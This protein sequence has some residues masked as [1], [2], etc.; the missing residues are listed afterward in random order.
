MAARERTSGKWPVPSGIGRGKRC[1]DVGCGAGTLSVQLAL[2]GA[3]QVTAIDI[4]KAAVANT[5][6][7]AFRNGVADHVD[8]EIVDLYAFHPQKQYDVIAASLYQMPT[9]PVGKLSS[10]RPVDFWG[11]NLLD[12]LIEMLPQL[13]KPDGIAYLLQ[14][15]LLSQSQTAQLFHDVGLE[16]RVVDFNLYEFSSV[17][18][19]NLDQIERV[20]KSSDAYHFKL[21]DQHVMVM[22]LLEVRRGND[23]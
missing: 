9:D 19:E 7:N 15:S 2:N 18:L 21:R 17:F 23:E 3:E 10:H 4:Q 12:H 8:G 16:S 11:R 20:E 22:Y 5:L 14:I 1:L 13:L 6:T